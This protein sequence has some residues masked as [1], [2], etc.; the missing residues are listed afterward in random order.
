MDQWL[1]Q[2]HD[3]CVLN[4]ILRK[5][6]HKL[7]RQFK[8]NFAQRSKFVRINNYTHKLHRWM[9]NESTTDTPSHLWHQP[10]V[11]H[12]KACPKTIILITKIT[13][14]RGWHNLT[15]LL[16]TKHQWLG[17]KEERIKL[18]CHL[19]QI[20]TTPEMWCQ[21]CPSLYI[22]IIIIIKSYDA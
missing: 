14:K 22:F 12:K 13:T 10:P 16:I 9:E 8:G 5:S 7:F 15:L 3:G 4:T 19:I 11:I 6:T 21:R 20:K 2:H 17:P 18:W 1:L